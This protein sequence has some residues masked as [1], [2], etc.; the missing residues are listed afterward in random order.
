LK[1]L[2]YIIKA[3]IEQIEAVTIANSFTLPSL[4]STFSLESEEP[5]MHPAIQSAGSLITS[6]AAQL[7]TLVRPVQHTLFDISLQ[8]SPK[9]LGA[10]RD[11]C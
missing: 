9:F 1:T 7:I 10:V 2:I 6:A 4:D 8:V 3:S 5:R 11:Y